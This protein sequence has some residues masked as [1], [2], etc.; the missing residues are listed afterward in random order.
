MHA[1]ITNAKHVAF[2]G[3]L[4]ELMSNCKNHPPE[5]RCPNCTLNFEVSYKKKTG[6]GRHRENASCIDC[7]PP[8]LQC[9]SQTYRHVDYVQFMNKPELDDFCNQWMSKGENR[10]GFLYGYYCEDPSYDEGIRAIVEA[11]YE[12]PQT[13]TWKDFELLHDLNASGVNMIARSLGLQK[14]GWIYTTR[15]TSIYM[16]PEK[17]IQA[18]E[19]QNKHLVNHPCG[20]KVPKWINVIMRDYGVMTNESG[21]DT[22]GIYPEVFMVNDQF[23]GIVRDGMLEPLQLNPKMITF[24]DS[25]IDMDVPTVLK[26]GAPT[27]EVEPEFWLVSIAN[28]CP[29]VN[30]FAVM[31]NYYFPVENRTGG[32]DP[33][34]LKNYFKRFKKDNGSKVWPK[35]AWANFHFLYYLGLLLDWETAYTMGMYVDPEAYLGEEVKNTTEILDSMI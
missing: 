3:Y 10:V 34:A 33:M 20:Y 13:G 11:I 21:Q 27:T 8:N 32:Q 22:G 12:P 17:I 35:D 14:I 5:A 9:K 28:G 24:K 4:K 30:K 2:D 31:K 18:A 23:G 26:G 15:D 6:C 19:F 7:Q 25:K 29:K 16:T 1:G